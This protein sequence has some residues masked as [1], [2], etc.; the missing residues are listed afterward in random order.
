MYQSSR[1]TRIFSIP[2][3]NTKIYFSVGLKNP[4]KNFFGIKSKAEKTNKKFIT[5]KYLI[6]ISL[7]GIKSTTTTLASHAGLRVISDSSLI[8]KNYCTPD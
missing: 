7:S 2:S 1:P 8:L 4:K 5:S 6:K 3:Y